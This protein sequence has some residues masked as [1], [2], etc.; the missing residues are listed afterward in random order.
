MLMFEIAR[1]LKLVSIVHIK[2]KKYDAPLYQK[3]KSS[4]LTFTRIMYYHLPEFYF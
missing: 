3:Q 1:Q 2:V 4:W